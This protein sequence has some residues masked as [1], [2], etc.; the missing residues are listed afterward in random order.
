MIAGE[1]LLAQSPNDCHFAEPRPMQLLSRGPS[2]G[3]PRT[4]AWRVPRRHRIAVALPCP[5]CNLV[6]LVTRFTD[7]SRLTRRRCPLLPP[8]AAAHS[9][10]TFV[11][12][13][14]PRSAGGTLSGV[15]TAAAAWRCRRG[16]CTHGRD[17]FLGPRAA[18]AGVGCFPRPRSQTRAWDPERG[19]ALLVPA[20]AAC[21]CPCRSS[22]EQRPS[23]PRADRALRNASAAASRTASS[24]AA[25]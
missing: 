19:G 20:S 4:L 11:V 7:A 10:E 8:A 21:P 18:R 15:V 1:S 16:R 24:P 6:P 3:V 17:S 2:F 14:M 13:L 25:R 23:S 12:D 22:A 5:R 9:T